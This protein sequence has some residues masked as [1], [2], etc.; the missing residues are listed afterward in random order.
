MPQLRVIPTE[1]LIPDPDVQLAFAL[2]PRRV[3]EMRA[4]WNPAYLAVLIVAPL[5]GEHEGMYGIID[6]R[7]RFLAGC[8]LATGPTEWR[9]DVHTDCTSVED[10]AR[11]KLAIDRDRR[12]VKGIEHYI[13]RRL[14][15]DPKV[16]A[17][18]AVMESTGF[19]IGKLSAGKPY[20]A[21][22]GG[23]GNRIHL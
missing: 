5:S 17:I 10:K 8:G 11:L 15:K 6:G 16:L 14:M 3:K 1:L 2:E 9:C 21:D 7:H 13:E 20:E 22:R 18:D 4:K 23:R 19:E 12:K